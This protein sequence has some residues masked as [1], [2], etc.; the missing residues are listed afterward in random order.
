M[1]ISL[2]LL[3]LA[4]LALA[5]D[6]TS[7]AWAREKFTEWMHRY[8]RSYSKDEFPYRFAA[9]RKN[10][11][12]VEYL[13]SA[14]IAARSGEAH[15]LNAFA[16]LTEAE[17]RAAHLGLARNGAAALATAPR[18]PFGTVSP[19][20][21]AAAPD[22]W[23][24]TEHGAVTEVKNQGQCGSCWSFSTT[25]NVEGQWFLAGNN[26]TSLSESN[27][28][29]CDYNP[30]NGNQGCNGGLPSLAYQF[31]IKQG[32]IDTEQAYPY[33]PVRDTCKFNPSAVGA[34]I[35]NWTA[36]PE[37]EDELAAWLWKNGP[38]SIGINAGWMQTYSHG[39]AKPLFCNPK[40]LDH[41]VL[42]VGYGTHKGL[43]GTEKFWKIKNSWGPG[44]GES[45][46]CRIIFGKGSCGLNTMA[47]SACVSDTCGAMPS[48]Q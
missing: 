10:M 33:A 24:W 18:L 17:F 47:T 43:F 46:Y 16:D 13:N 21:V 30:P 14:S 45:G 7:D 36:L 9:F 2:A 23:D 41:G 1:K 3:A 22:A 6:V 34:K 4:P 12:K 40:A 39:I 11:E 19:Q 37:S 5:Q 31:I 15:A 38:I 25:G 20:D 28:V 27:L 26:L 48:S 42:L 29:D 32:G 44:W 8:E 35:A